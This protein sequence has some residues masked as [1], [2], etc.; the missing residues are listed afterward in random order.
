M[1]FQAIINTYRDFDFHRYWSSVCGEDVERS[2]AK[3]KLSNTDFLNLLSPIASEYIEQMAQKAHKLTVQH[4]GQTIQL[5]IPLYV[6][7]YCTN[8]CAYCGFN[9]KHNIHRQI[10]NFDEIE[11]EARAIARTGMQH[12]LFLTGESPAHTPMDYLQKTA[13]CLKNHFASVSIE[14]FPMDE[15]DYSALNMAGVDGM[16]IFQETYDE[17]VYHRVHPAGP[18]KNYRYRLDAPERGARAGFRL[19][20]IGALLGLGEPRRDIFFTALHGHYL[21]S[22]CLETEVSISLPRFNHAEGSF[23]PDHLVDD[24]TFVQ[25]ITALRLFSPKT[26]ITISTRENAT[27]RD[28]LIPLG[29][30]RYSAGSSTGV[31]GYEDTSSAQNLQFE[32]TDCRTVDEVAA[33]I[34]AAGYQ[35][36]YKDWDTIA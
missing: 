33:A 26:G 29:A 6:S 5:F 4:F 16:T 21:E 13:R 22:T 25:F 23:Q 11:T 30:T 15:P 1:S 24:R 18:K 9:R 31:G 34:V 10:L 36:I 12:V 17:E 2:L 28:S 3:E 19:V 8:Q 20:N 35:P 32:I 14:V 7:N 27:L